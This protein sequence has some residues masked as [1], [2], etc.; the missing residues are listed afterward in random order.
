MGVLKYGNND[1]TKVL[2]DAKFVL[3]NSDKSKVAKITDGKLVRWDAVT[4]DMD[5]TPYE[6]VTGDDGK[7]TIKGLD[8]DKYYL[9]ETQAPAGYN[10][11]SADVKVTV[12]GIV[13]G[14]HTAVVAKIN[15]QSG[16]VLPSTGGIGTTLFYIVGGIMAVGAVVALITKKRMEE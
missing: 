2:K 7:I 13:D 10:K 9:R 1:E 15:N 12:T 8:A 4:D 3:L 16:T 14:T 5:L 6:L 11:L